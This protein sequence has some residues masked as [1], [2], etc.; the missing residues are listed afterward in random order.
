MSWRSIGKPVAITPDNAERF[1]EIY[2]RPVPP[3]A[4]E[5]PRVRFVRHP[6]LYRES[7]RDERENGRT[8][9]L[10]VSV[11]EREGATLSSFA[12]EQGTSLDDYLRD[13]IL[14]RMWDDIEHRRDGERWRAYKADPDAWWDAHKAGACDDE[15]ADE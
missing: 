8:V 6:A 12:E 7:L 9:S 4:L 2:G 15:D 14:E 11:T 3:M 1:A 5:G 10:T 13:A